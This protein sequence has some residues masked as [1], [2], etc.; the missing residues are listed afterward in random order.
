LIHYD[1]RQIIAELT[2]MLAPVEVIE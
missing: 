1:D 2:G